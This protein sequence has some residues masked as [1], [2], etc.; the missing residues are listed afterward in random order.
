MNGH[1][2]NQQ[3]IGYAIGG[4]VVVAI[5]YFRVMR[6]RVARP[7]KIEY[8]WVV[9]LIMILLGAAMTSLMLAAVHWQITTNALLMSGG[10]LLAGA[11]VGWGRGSM[12]R[13]VVDPETRAVT[14]Q[15]SGVALIILILLLVGRMA[16]RF[17]FMADL[18]PQS[19]QAMYINIA[20]FLFAIGFLTVARLEMW[21][22][23]QR[24]LAAARPA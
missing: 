3:M 21:L 10:G 12:T 5:L 15:A 18:D 20:F 19:P 6:A 2:S 11:A 14:A 16:L 4:V 9:P 17:F 8:L 13:L 24:L 22:R 23:A 7:I 1:L